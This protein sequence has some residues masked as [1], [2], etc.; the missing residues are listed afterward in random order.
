MRVRTLG[1]PTT[2]I[3]PQ[4]RLAV[5]E[6]TDDHI[7]ISKH[8]QPNIGDDIGVHRHDFDIGVHVTQHFGC[9]HRFR[10][11]TITTAKQHSA[12]EVGFFDLVE[13]N[14]VDVPHAQ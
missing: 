8:P 2:A 6:T 4:T 10:L 9:H 14:N 11:P 13:I 1:L 7:H 3:H 5:V 12:G